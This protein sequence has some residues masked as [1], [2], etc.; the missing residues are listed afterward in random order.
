MRGSVLIISGPSGVG[1]S[2]ISRALADRL[3][4]FLSVSVTTRP[5]ADT[6]AKGLDYNFV[7]PAKFDEMRKN[8]EFLES[9]DLYGFSYGTLRQPVEHAMVN[10]RLVILEIDVEGARQVKEEMPGSRALFILPP[11]ED[12]LLDRLKRR[13]L[14]LV[15]AQAESSGIYDYF[16]VNDN[17]ERAISESLSWIRGETGKANT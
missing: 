7:V 11:S 6:E 1:K 14:R 8:G 3:G 4:A 9:A 13:P 17:L 5:S 12:T 16:V 15:P 10:G 2:K